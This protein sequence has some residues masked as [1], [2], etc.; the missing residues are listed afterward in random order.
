MEM[1]MKAEGV[2]NLSPTLTRS[3]HGEPH[4]VERCGDLQFQQSQL[5]LVG[6]VTDQTVANKAGACGRLSVGIQMMDW[7][8]DGEEEDGNESRDDVAADV[9]T[10]VREGN[11]AAVLEVFIAA[12]A[13]HRS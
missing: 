1:E 12:P 4:L 5:A 10:V 9:G 2:Y 8:T 13:H 11:A 7:L 6:R 3:S